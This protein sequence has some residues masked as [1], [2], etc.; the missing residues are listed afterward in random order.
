[1]RMNAIRE[2]FLQLVKLGIGTDNSTSIPESVEWAEIK[3]L[4][5]KQGLLA[6]VLDG[7]DRLSRKRPD[8]TET[9]PVQEKLEWI[10]EILQNYEGRFSAY[11]KAIGELAGWYQEHGYRM[12]ILKGYSCSLDWP[13]PN[14]RPCGDIDIWQFGEQKE[15]DKTLIKKG[16]KVDSSHHHHTV[17][18]WRGFS[19]E[20]HFDFINVHHH[21]S[22]VYLEKVLK[23]MGEDDTHYLEINGARVYL[24][25]PNLQALFLLRHTMTD[26]AASGICLR[27][28]LDWAF[29]VTEHTNEVDWDWLEDIL[30]Q[31]GMKRLYDVFNA[32]CVG[33]LGFPVDIFKKVQFDPILKEMVLK[34]ILSPEFPNEIPKALLS[35]V[36][37]KINRW[38]A[39][40][41]K[42]ELVY[43]ESMWS[44]FWSG[45]WNHLLKPAS[46]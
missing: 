25:A 35:R 24:P 42:H 14:H 32:I 30:E 44:A 18:A 20:N 11:K 16:I 1:M 22:N 38:K 6:V 37:W 23:K 26:F 10:G 7:I 46:I 4:A 12:M 2:L 28:L 27:Q 39:N 34:D 41:W 15:A 31:Y 19:V 13:K 43:K 9:L 33:N 17:F 40:E 21:K 3:E 29:F 45:V 5:D 36:K 8:I